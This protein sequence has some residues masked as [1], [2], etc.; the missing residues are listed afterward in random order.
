MREKPV[1]K[2][3]L[4]TMSLK[5]GGAETYI[6][7]FAKGLKKNGVEVFVASAGGV[8]ADELAGEEIAHFRAPLNTKR[9]DRMI[10]SYRILKRI[11]T[12]NGIRMVH[13]HARIPAFICGILCRRLN[14]NFVTTAHWVFRTPLAYR[15][16]SNWGQASLAVSVDIKEYLIKNYGYDPE[17]IIVTINGINTER[18]RKGERNGGIIDEFGLDASKKRVICSC[19]MDRAKNRP[20]AVS[21]AHALIDAAPGLYETFDGN[22][23]IVLVGDGDDYAEIVK[24]AGEA[25]S[26]AGGRVVVTTGARTD[27]S[28]FLGISDVFVGVS[29]SA[30]EAMSAEVPLILAGNEGYIG[31]F[32][33]RSLDDAV[34][35]NFCCRGNFPAIDSGKLAGDICEL[36]AKPENE[37]K[38]LGEYG[39]KVILKNYSADIMVD[40]AFALYKMVLDLPAGPE[41]LKKTDACISG[42][43]GSKNHGDDALLAAI[44]NDLRAVKKDVRLV[45]F[46][47]RPRETAKLHGVK[48]VHTFNFIRIISF[49]KNTGLLISGGGTLVQDQT[50]T[51]SLVYYLFIMNRAVANGAKLMLYACGV[52]PLRHEKNRARAAK[53]L[54]KAELITLRDEMSLEALR[55]IGITEKEQRIVITADA[56][57]GLKYVAGR[58]AV[59]RAELAGVR[60]KYFCVAVRGWKRLKPDFEDVIAGFAD[61]ISDKYGYAALF[62]PMQPARDTDISKRI[63]ARA[64]HEGFILEGSQSVNCLLGVVANSEFVL[65]MRLHTIIYAAKTGTPVIGLAYDPKINGMMDIFEQKF[66]MDVEKLTLDGLIEYADMIVANRGDISSRLADISAGLEEKSAQTAKLALEIMEKNKRRRGV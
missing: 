18:F 28:K 42:Y 63:M 43:Y 2:V 40:H 56:V 54:K 14:L 61:Y 44:V 65:G 39:R 23:E 41:S 46:S 49:L 47:K 35:S 6:L 50:S 3:L 8:Y 52:G 26:R 38:A 45:V 20:G 25:N 10:K 19:R 15:L 21:A 58:D 31:I 34:Y 48:S 36:F 60:G 53:T 9:P 59:R 24:K 13:A 64:K 27:V 57:F 32:D 1:E 30:M 7:E 17:R 55:E 66:Y 16:L 62:I 4:V 22:V 29:R 11:V 5:I 51:K 37:R 12:E 33:E